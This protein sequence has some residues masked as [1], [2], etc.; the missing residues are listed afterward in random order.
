MP[1]ILLL[2]A[3]GAGLVILGTRWYR[4]EKRRIAAE[5][6]SAKEA[7]EHR[8]RES[9]VPLEQDPSTGVYRPKRVLHEAQNTRH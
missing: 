1:Q 7:M 6:R 3:A 5:L 4:N 9:A 2:I 8:D